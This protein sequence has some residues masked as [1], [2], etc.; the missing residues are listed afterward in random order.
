MPSY[1]SNQ[2]GIAALLCLLMLSA[3]AVAQRA[4]SDQPLNLI[5]DAAIPDSVVAETKNEQQS[6]KANADDN[7]TVANDADQG[8]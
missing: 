6:A 2:I 5:G 8:F 7:Q 1:Q 4:D 3:P